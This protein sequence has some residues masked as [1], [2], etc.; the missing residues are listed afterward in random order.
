M[1]ARQPPAQRRTVPQPRPRPKSP[2]AFRPGPSQTL[3]DAIAAALRDFLTPLLGSLPAALA[4]SSGQAVQQAIMDTPAAMP[5]CATCIV[6]SSHWQ[7]RHAGDWRT[8][9]ERAQMAAA[10]LAQAQQSG[11]PAGAVS[12]LLAQ[13]SQAGYNSAWPASPQAP[14]PADPAA[15]LPE[16]LQPHPVY[17]YKDEHMP[18]VL[19][20]ITYHQGTA[21]C[22]F[23][24]PGTPP[25]DPGAPQVQAKPILLAPPGV[26][27]SVAAAAA[28]QGAPGMPGYAQQ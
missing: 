8:A 27:L 28:R 12:A 2:P 4:Q 5:A 16:N 11:D 24:L 3:A 22:M 19:P 6:R 21:V 7:V 17:P 23:D 9:N 25:F 13:M 1:T 20:S 26:P 18:R 14:S 10:Q 15:W